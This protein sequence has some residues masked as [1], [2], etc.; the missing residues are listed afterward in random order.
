MYKEQPATNTRFSIGQLQP[1]SPLLRLLRLYN[2]GIL[3]I[4]KSIS[5]A[6]GI[7]PHPRRLYTLFC[8][9]ARYRMCKSAMTDQ[10][11]IPLWTISD[12]TSQ[13]VGSLHH[14]FRLDAK[15]ANVAIPVGEQM[16]N[17]IFIHQIAKHVLD[18]FDFGTSVH[19]FVAGLLG[20]WHEQDLHASVDRRLETNLAGL[21]RA[22]HWAGKKQI[23]IIV[24]GKVLA[25]FAAL[26]FAFF[27]EQGVAD[28]F[29]VPGAV[30]KALGVTDEV[31][32]G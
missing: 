15:A 16:H 2:L 21:D 6:L 13:H 31:E 29:T 9:V 17:T 12:K 22:F 1:R 25:Q 7:L 23:D 4:I 26:G 10:Y 3:A 30:V 18:V 19:V 20:Q 27:G 5:P 24:V 32:C 11:N 14:N 8:I 28:S